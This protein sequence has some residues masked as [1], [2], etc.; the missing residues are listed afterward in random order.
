MVK[1]CIEIEFELYP[2][3]ITMLSPR[4]HRAFTIYA[5]SSI[6]NII[7]NLDKRL[8]YL[9][10]TEEN[11]INAYTIL[12]FNF[13]DKFQLIKDYKIKLNV[14]FGSKI[15]DKIKSI[16]ELEI[17]KNKRELKE[18]VNKYNNNR[19]IINKIIK[20][21][22]QLKGL[23]IKNCESLNIDIYE[24]KNYYNFEEEF[25][26]KIFDKFFSAEFNPKLLNKNKDS[27]SSICSI[28]S[29]YDSDMKYIDKIT[30]VISVVLMEEDSISNMCE[31]LDKLIKKKC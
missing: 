1:R 11:L 22:N 6:S 28:I 18:L 5:S 2:G 8:Q 25:Y 31:N 16:R 17:I 23:N 3:D 4:L 15:T 20:E 9:C 21:I 26:S 19:N 14:S 7:G 12:Q 30:S 29:Y 13:E 24:E 10:N 27:L